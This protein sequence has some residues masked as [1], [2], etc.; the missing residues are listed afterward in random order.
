MFDVGEVLIGLLAL[1]FIVLVVVAS[2][3]AGAQP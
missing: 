2:T 1:T 3:L